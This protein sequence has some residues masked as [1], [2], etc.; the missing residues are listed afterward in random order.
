MEKKG[1]KIIRESEL[2]SIDD[3][4]KEL[5]KKCDE[6]RYGIFFRQVNVLVGSLVYNKKKVDNALLN[7]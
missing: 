1:R 3:F 4:L 5:Q 2:G 6:R 7:K